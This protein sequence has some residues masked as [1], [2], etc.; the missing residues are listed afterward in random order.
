M[1]KRKADPPISHYPE[2]YDFPDK[3]YQAHWEKAT[4]W[5]IVEE[6]NGKRELRACIETCPEEWSNRLIITELWVH[7]E[8]R[9]QGVGHQL[10]AIAKEQAKRKRSVLLFWKRNP[11]MSERL[12]FI[13]KKAL[14]SLVLTVAAILIRICKEEKCDWIWAIF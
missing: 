13:E 7:E 9:R 4:A 8:M 12:H 11:A 14:C 10:M 5:G 2:K 1:Q 3:L 6:R